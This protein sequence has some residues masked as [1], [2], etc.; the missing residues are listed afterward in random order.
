[1]R[2][3][4]GDDSHLTIV[5]FGYARVPDHASRPDK[6][7]EPE[8][9]EYFRAPECRRQSGGPFWYPADVYSVGAIL[10]DFILG[11][12]AGKILL[13]SLPKDVRALK[14]M[15]SHALTTTDSAGGSELI[16]EDKPKVVVKENQNIL[17]ILDSCL[18]Y[19]VDDRITSMEDLIDIVQT[20][21]HVDKNHYSRR[22]TDE[23]MAYRRPRESKGGSTKSTKK[24]EAALEL[25][26]RAG[27]AS[28]GLAAQVAEFD[29]LFQRHFGSE[30]V[31]RVTHE[32]GS[33]D[34][35]HLEVFGSRDRIISSLCNLLGSARDGDEYCT[36]TLPDYWS[37]DNLGSNGRFLTMNKHVT[38]A[39]IRIRRVYLVDR[40]FHELSDQEQYILE[41]QL[42]TSPS[43][44][45]WDVRVRLVGADE[46]ATFEEVGSTVAFLKRARKAAE[47][48]P[49]RRF[50]RMSL[51]H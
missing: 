32:L 6:T 18:R 37:D 27:L 24:T 33:L 5:G 51:F 38:T 10:V 9:D 1:M 43:P 36:L 12:E 31:T 28:E 26:A 2:E 13:R 16:E 21:R 7:D 14:G 41:Q 15:L 35:R 22:V 45:Y 3:V 20:A 40:T 47:P 34:T 11:R 17:K 25:L 44:G 19:D 23:V 30:L 42:W 8:E 29:S 4:A 46:L 50:R 39:G 49:I 48:P